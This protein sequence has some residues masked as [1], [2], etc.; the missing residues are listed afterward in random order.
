[1]FPSHDLYAMED[2]KNAGLNPIL[3]GKV[4]GAPVPSGAMPVMQPVLGQ[5]TLSKAGQNIATALNASEQTET[6]ELKQKIMDLDVNE[7][8]FNSKI[9][10]YANDLL[11]QAESAV[12]SGKELALSKLEATTK[13]AI[14]KAMQ[15]G[16]KNFY[17]KLVQHFKGNNIVSELLD[18]MA[19]WANSIVGKTPSE[20]RNNIK[21]VGKALVPQ[22][23]NPNRTKKP[24]NHRSRK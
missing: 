6:E 12:K 5:E 3:A 8:E 15:G 2:M 16:D 1:M 10:G 21:K 24:G 14:K 18:D 13:M 19:D 4:G 7:K 11:G 20:A 23:S 22:G 9:W 17:K